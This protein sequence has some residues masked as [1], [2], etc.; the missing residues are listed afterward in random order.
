M[1]IPP[2]FWRGFIKSIKNIPMMIL[3]LLKIWEW[4]MW[5]PWTKC[6]WYRKE[7]LEDGDSSSHELSIG[8]PCFWG[9]QVE[10]GEV[11]ET[12][13]SVSHSPEST[14][15][16][17]KMNHILKKT[18][19]KLSQETHLTWERELLLALLHIR[20]AP[21]RGLRGSS[22]GTP[23]GRSLLAPTHIEGETKIKQSIQHLN[24]NINH[25][26]SWLAS[27]MA[28]LLEGPL[29]PFQSG[30][31]L[32]LKTW[33]GHALDQKST[34]KWVGPYDVLQA[35]TSSLKLGKENLWIHELNSAH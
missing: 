31:K 15:K 19:T 17:K 23:Y 13:C 7:V 3:R 18:I 33:K 1:M 9:I 25:H 21:Q 11:C 24:Q 20:V 4:F 34:D 6:P 5:L 26:S 30:D 2:S 12:S 27:R 29:H 28:S 22:Y 10:G 32:F 14:R 16:M 8:R 35:T